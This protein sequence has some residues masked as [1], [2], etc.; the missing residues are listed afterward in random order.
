MTALTGSSYMLKF[1]FDLIAFPF[2]LVVLIVCIPIQACSTAAAKAS[3]VANAF[4]RRHADECPLF[5][6]IPE[7]PV[8]TN[9]DAAWPPAPHAVEALAVQELIAANGKLIRDLC[10]ATT[11]DDVA[12]QKILLPVITNLARIVHLC[13]AS[14]FDH[15][16]GYGGLFTHSLEVAYFAANT[17]KAKIFDR[18][19]PPKDQYFNKCRWI[20]T[21]VLAALA[22]D[23]GK[24]FSDM[25]ITTADGLRWDHQGPILDWL[26]KNR[27]KSYFIA[28]KQGR[29]HN[30]HK[31]FSLSKSAELIPQKTWDFIALTGYGEA[32][33][34]EFNDAVLLGHKG[35]LIGRI[36]DNADG[37]SRNLDMK[38]QRQIKAE[39]K[40]VSH[41]QAN[42]LL[43]AIR[44]LISEGVWSVNEE[45]SKVFITKQGCY[46]VWNEGIA[47]QARDKAQSYGAVSIPLDYIRLAAML[48]EIGVVVR[49]TDEVSSTFNLFWQVTPIVLG[50]T[51]LSCIRISNPQ[52]IFDMA[53]PPAIEAIVEGLAI[54]DVTKQAWMDKWK[55]IPK[56]KI[57][58]AEE[59]LMGYTPD[60]AQQ[61][62]EEAAAREQERE[63]LL[64]AESAVPDDLWNELLAG[65]PTPGSTT[66]SVNGTGHAPS[67][68]SISSAFPSEPPQAVPDSTAT[69][70]FEDGAKK[71][72]K[73]IDESG[74][75]MAA[76]MGM[77]SASKGEAPA[78]DPA[79][80]P[81]G[82]S[83]SETQP[84]P[85]PPL[86]VEA[87][88][89]P[90]DVIE[91]ADPDTMIGTDPDLSDDLIPDPNP[92]LIEEPDLSGLWPS[93]MPSEP[94]PLPAS[95]PGQLS[96]AKPPA[97]DEDASARKTADS[98]PRGKSTGRSRRDSRTEG[99]KVF[100]QTKD[101]VES[102]AQQICMR[103]GLWLD[104][105]RQ[106]DIETGKWFTGSLPFEAELAER[107][108]EDNLLRLVL[109]ELQE[110][111]VQPRIELDRAKH[112]VYLIGND[113]ELD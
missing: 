53:V 59:E 41:P 54:D 87:D 72:R 52:L 35:G 49:S 13:P 106:M 93:D 62:A 45:N 103:S 44:S 64:A 109:D 65:S 5:K 48:A 38:R 99:E 29:E 17:A 112:R 31:S 67:P 102:M 32:M 86:P 63:E 25:E 34:K 43:K 28:F 14:E 11:L 30:A 94:S 23:I 95:S 70:P 24:P 97:A 51:Q 79:R 21:A 110:Q 39:F 60:F 85:E 55:F 66:A 50:T 37:I 104:G 84:A 4:S 69:V 7:K 20:L 40:N 18:S 68:A 10:Y 3:A 81:T 47:A 77:N 108:I 105:G 26:R 78:A 71:S 57:S 82:S 1:I 15:H 74:F 89:P 96:A 22:H 42:E 27:V 92:G 46:L 76:L 36:L 113:M 80:T 111:D 75:D 19:A 2:R 73:A 33:L 98:S 91:A 90:V 8:M 16:Q 100:E 58:R 6:D 83:K 61:L 12:T 56:I 9:L 107:G 88:Q 101:L